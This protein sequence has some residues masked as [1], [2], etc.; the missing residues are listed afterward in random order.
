MPLAHILCKATGS[1]MV[2]GGSIL[3]S[4]RHM[5]HSAFRRARGRTARRQRAQPICCS[6]PADCALRRAGLLLRSAPTR[7]RKLL[8]HVSL[9]LPLQR[10]QRS[11]RSQLTLAAAPPWLACLAIS[12]QAHLQCRGQ[13]RTACQMRRR[14]AAHTAQIFMLQAFKSVNN[15]AWE[16]RPAR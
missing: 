7:T 5:Q 15:T 11:V 4:P 10:V 14:C 3:R 9:R 1:P 16:V 12:Q 6:Q 8:H 13:H 2:P